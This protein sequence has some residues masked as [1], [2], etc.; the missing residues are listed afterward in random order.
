MELKSENMIHCACPSV[1]T[2]AAVVVTHGIQNLISDAEKCLF[3]LS[4]SPS[5]LLLSPLFKEMDSQNYCLG[6]VLKCSKFSKYGLASISLPASL[7]RL[8]LELMPES[9]NTNLESLVFEES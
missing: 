4:V 2:L 3:F 6:T 7:G 5:L 8:F 9:L 1:F